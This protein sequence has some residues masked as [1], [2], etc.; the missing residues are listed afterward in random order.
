MISLTFSF[1]GA[2]TLFH[3][4]IVEIKKSSIITVMSNDMVKISEIPFPA[5]TF[6]H[7]VRAEEREYFYKILK[8]FYVDQDPKGI[9]T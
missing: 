5:V 1:L 4:L 7:E 6:C 9:R 3:K 8:S 2:F